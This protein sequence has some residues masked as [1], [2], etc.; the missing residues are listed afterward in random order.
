MNAK[1]VL[2]ILKKNGFVEIS[3]K[4]SHIKLSNN[5]KIVIVPMHGSKEIPIGTLKNISKQSGIDF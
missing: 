3:Q 4:G 1:E 5:S 2:R